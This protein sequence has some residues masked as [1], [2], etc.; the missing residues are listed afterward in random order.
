M[1]VRGLISLMTGTRTMGKLKNLYMMVGIAAILSGCIGGTPYEEAG[2]LIPKVKANQGRIFAY[3]N[4]SVFSNMVR[5]VLYVDG[6]PVADVLSGK[7]TFINIKPGKHFITFN[8][9]LNR[10]N[11]NVPRGKTIYLRYEIVRDDVA[12][13][14]TTVTVIPEKTAKKDIK[15]TN[16]I[17]AKIRH[18]DEL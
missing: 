4:I 5:R 9:G 10:L 18:P 1:N 7:S 2:A 11:I 8:K 3:R 16:L 13:G 12:K 15:S 6:K 14:N 17:E